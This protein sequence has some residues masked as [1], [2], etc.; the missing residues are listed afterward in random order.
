MM[1]TDKP[2]AYKCVDISRRRAGHCADKVLRWNKPDAPHMIDIMPLF[3]RREWV[4]LTDAEI[5]ECNV[6]DTDCAH[7]CGAYQNILDFA[8]AIQAK[9]KER[10]T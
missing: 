2:V 9:I 7:I 8:K 3:E 5:W 1:K 4:G 10:N 6:E